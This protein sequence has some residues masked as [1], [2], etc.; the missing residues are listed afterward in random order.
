MVGTLHSCTTKVLRDGKALR[1][2][3]LVIVEKQLMKIRDEKIT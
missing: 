3:L 2:M 1:D